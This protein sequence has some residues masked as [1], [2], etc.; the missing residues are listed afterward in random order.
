MLSRSLVLD[1]CLEHGPPR[2][3]VTES[4]A[5]N[6]LQHFQLRR[7][8]DSC[9]HSCLMSGVAPG[10]ERATVSELAGTAPNVGERGPWPG[11]SSRQCG[12]AKVY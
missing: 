7:N 6:W 8:Q 11:A 5:C 1:H 4:Q 3:V 2:G 12:Y 9:G 10:R